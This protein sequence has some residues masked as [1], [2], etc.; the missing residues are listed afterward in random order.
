M[1][2]LEIIGFFWVMLSVALVSFIALLTVGVCIYSG[3]AVLRRRYMRGKL[4]ELD[5][6]MKQD[7]IRSALRG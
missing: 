2:S 1:N 4:L 5:D 6:I 7:E 3:V